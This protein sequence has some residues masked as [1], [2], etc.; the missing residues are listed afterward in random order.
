[1]SPLYSLAACA[2]ALAENVRLEDVESAAM[3]AGLR[4][5]TQGRLDEAE[6]FFRIYLQSEDP[7]SASAYSNLVR[8]GRARAGCRQLCRNCRQ[9][10]PVITPA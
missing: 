8:N 2:Q 9:I 4:A 3:Q 10:E 5:A 7:A 6:R 1:M